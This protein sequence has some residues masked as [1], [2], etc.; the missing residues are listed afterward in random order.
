MVR[1]QNQLLWHHDK[2]LPVSKTVNLNYNSNG[3]R[4]LVERRART[5]I[6]GAILT[7]KAFSRNFHV[8]GTWLSKQMCETNTWAS[9]TDGKLTPAA[10]RFALSCT[11][12]VSASMFLSCAAFVSSNTPSH[13][14]CR[15]R[16]PSLAWTLIAIAIFSLFTKKEQE[17]SF[18]KQR[19]LMANTKCLWFGL[20]ERKREESQLWRRVWRRIVYCGTCNVLLLTVKTMCESTSLWNKESLKIKN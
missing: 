9:S 12:H 7:V 11:A 20:R 17:G 8:R 13:S 16:V 10:L 15:C 14:R 3:K 4:D 6:G 19:K 1:T 5:S 18:E 2:L